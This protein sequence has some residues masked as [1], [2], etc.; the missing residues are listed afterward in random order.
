MFLNGEPSPKPF[1]K[2]KNKKCSSRWSLQKVVV[3]WKWLLSTAG[4]FNYHEFDKKFKMYNNVSGFAIE[5]ILMENEHPVAKKQ[6][7]H[8]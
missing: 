5:D 8:K 4:V 6:K 1:S 2:I 7:T 3:E